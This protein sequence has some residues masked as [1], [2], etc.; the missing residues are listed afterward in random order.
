ML[1]DGVVIHGACSVSVTVK[2][3]SARKRGSQIVL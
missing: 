2:T 1:V 3:V